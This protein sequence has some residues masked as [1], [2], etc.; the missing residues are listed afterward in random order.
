M[1]LILITGATGFLGGEVVRQALAR[2]HEARAL[3]RSAEAAAALPV[4]KE[5]LFLADLAR[6]GAGDPLGDAEAAFAGIDA[7]IHC[8]AIT[9]ERPTDA[10]LSRRVNVDA[11]AAL[12]RAAER[13]GSP[14]WIQISSM[15][16]SDRAESVYGKTKFEADQAVRASALPWTILRPSVIYGPG[17]RGVAARTARTLRRL[18][19]LPIIGSGEEV[20]RP[21]YVSDVAEAAFAA[22]E[23]EAAIGKAYMIGGADEVTLEDFM[24]RLATAAGA[25]RL[26]IYV[27][28]WAAMAVA[29][30]AALCMKNPPLT[31]DN[32]LG[33]KLAEW[34]DVAPARADL[35]FKPMG[36]EEGLRRTFP[37]RRA[38]SA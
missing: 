29:R 21:V 22:I 13:A 19:F 3:V 26:A 5:N 38:G 34:M 35:D 23:R 32:V 33:V 31:V 36:L 1:P 17:E 16:A 10:G 18:P 15:S 20:L 37:P 7:V 2:G 8:A 11:T 30:A 9:P 25:S 28:I 6:L 27:P 4:K 14:R 24:R 12:L